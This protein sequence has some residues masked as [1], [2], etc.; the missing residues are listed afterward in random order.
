MISHRYRCIFVHQRK[1][2]GTTVKALFDDV[3]PEDRGRFNDGILSPDWDPERPPV[4]DHFAFT[5]IRNP[6]DRFVSGWKYCKTTK[7]RDILDVLANLPRRRLIDTVLARRASWPARIESARELGRQAKDEAKHAVRATL[8]RADKRPKRPGHDYRHL[9]QMQRATVVWP[10]GRLAVDRV[11][12]LEDL[13]AGLAEVFA[14]I[15]KPYAAPPRER[16]R[17][18]G[19]DYRRHFDDPRARAL[20]DAAFG[21]DVACWGYDFDSGLPDFARFAGAGRGAPVAAPIPPAADGRPP[22]DRQASRQ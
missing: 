16:A 4:S 17:R 12:F 19:D 9:T 20:F 1:S 10:D 3:G 18:R 22:R 7:H 6:W 11:V 15:G 14:A 8:G 13:D 2:A 21:A 5:V